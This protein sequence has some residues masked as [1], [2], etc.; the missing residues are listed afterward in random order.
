MRIFPGTSFNPL[1][2]GSPG[3]IVWAL[4]WA[5]AFSCAKV[6]D[7]LPPLPPD[8]VTVE[9]LAV[10]QSGREVLLTFPIPSL[11]ITGIEIYRV[12]AED[13]ETI[14]S[15]APVSE[16][17]GDDIRELGFMERM[18]VTAPPMADGSEC[19]YAIRTRGER[20]GRSG[21]SNSVTWNNLQPP[22]P[23]EGLS[24]RTSEESVRIDW[25]PPET[26]PSAR[27]DEVIEYLI[28][29]RELRLENRF[30]VNDFTFGEPLEFEVR[31]LERR[32]G[33]ILLS[34]PAS[35][36][37]FIPEDVF[38]P[39]APSGLVAVRLDN[40]VQLSWDDNDETDLA[41]YYVYRLD[42]NGEAERISGLMTLNRFLDDNPPARRK[43]SYYVTSV[44]KWNN[45]SPPSLTSD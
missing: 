25:N 4:L 24:A 31:T 9:D 41:G 23:P 20:G 19:T 13:S 17:P 40:G 30:T 5:A 1:R 12:C 39:Q 32:E 6:G 44:D 34:E 27:E 11:N 15:T 38:P 33:T 7:P 21:L 45:E 2:T 43:A 28:D 37:D 14:S 10:I 35:L 8:S 16:V 29:F 22:S 36:E 3:L 26:A 18:Y 42:A